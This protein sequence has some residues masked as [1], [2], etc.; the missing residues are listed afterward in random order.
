MIVVSVVP[1]T[2]VGW[3]YVSDTRELLTGDAQELAQ[4]RVKQLRMKTEAVVDD[5]VR[6]AMGVARVPQFFSLPIT[7]QRAHIAAILNQQRDLTALTVLAPTG[8]AFRACR[9][10][11]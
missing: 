1:T 3:L 10:S 8:C 2:M 5:P 4:E 6:G 11:Q 9:R 7:E